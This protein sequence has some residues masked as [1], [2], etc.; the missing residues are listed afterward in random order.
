[1]TVL[2]CSRPVSA[3]EAQPVHGATTTRDTLIAV[4]T[5]THDPIHIDGELDEPSWQSAAP[6]GPLRQVV[7]VEG[8]AASEQTVVRVLYDTDALYVAIVCSDH[9]PRHR[10]DPADTRCGP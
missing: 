9:V 8:H 5:R 4:A 3:G 10:G 1:M 6:I 7:P 2:V